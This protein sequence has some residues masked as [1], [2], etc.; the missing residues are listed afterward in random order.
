MTLRRNIAGIRDAKIIDLC[1]IMLLIV[2]N[3][4]I[5]AL[6]YTNYVVFY[7]NS[8]GRGETTHLLF[9][10]RSEATLEAFGYSNSDD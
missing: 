5:E 3:K 7:L 4:L 9:P 2:F 10:T 8:F 6:L 1:T